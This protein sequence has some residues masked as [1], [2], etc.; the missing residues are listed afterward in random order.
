MSNALE[1]LNAK[2][3]FKENLVRIWHGATLYQDVINWNR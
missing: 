3:Y 2:N 1:N